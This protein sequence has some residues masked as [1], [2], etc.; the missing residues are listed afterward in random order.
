M[1]CPSWLIL[2]MVT[3]LAGALLMFKSF[4]Q[5]DHQVRVYIAVIKCSLY[6]IQR[7]WFL[8]PPVCN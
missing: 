2:C 6:L 8:I 3:Q 4:L 1:Q 7:I 5:L